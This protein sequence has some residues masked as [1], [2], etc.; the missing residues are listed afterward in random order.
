[1]Q[2]SAKTVS[3]SVQRLKIGFSLELSVG[4]NIT[5]RVV[6][7]PEETDLDLAVLDQNATVVAESS[8]DDGRE[9]IEFNAPADGS[10][11]LRVDGYRDQAAFYSLSI[12]GSCTLDS[13]CPDGQVCDRFESECVT[14]GG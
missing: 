12:S 11:Y 10:Y 14:P 1:M 8:T 6:A 9:T 3:S 13:Q 2:D 5:I 7:D 4:Q